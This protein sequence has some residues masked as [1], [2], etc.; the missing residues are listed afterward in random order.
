MSILK[1]GDTVAFIAPSSFV[2]KEDINA[3]VEYFKQM[4]L[5]VK[6]AD[7]ICE[8]YRYM[9]GDDKK[10]AK[11]INKMFAD[12]DIKALVCVRGGA[13]SSRILSLLDYNLIKKNKKI[14]I[15][16]SDSTALQNALINLSLTPS[17][18]G[19]L[20]SYKTEQNN[21]NDKAGRYLYSIL[22]DNYHEICSGQCLI[23][24]EAE[25][26]I[27]GGNLSVLT[28][29]CGTKYFPSLKD[30]ILL[31]EEVGE[32][33]HKID[34]MLNQLKQQKDFDKLKGIIIGQFSNCFATD[35][36]DGTVED[37]IKDFISCCKIPTIYNF[38]YGHIE[39]S[40]IIPLGIKVKII[41]SVKQC[42]ISWKN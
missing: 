28:Y 1:K 14:V 37:C 30:K 11:I 35:T 8:E 29:L 3:S 5:K 38:M 9:A 23:K 34:L 6:I 42:S 21:S 18:S 16:L 40:Q 26:K 39:H 25:G 36:F 17:Y 20:A 24:G 4:G 27:V 15:G 41:S 7:N 13:G 33:V 22:F 31:I 10:R 2:K 12:K 19:Y 32:K